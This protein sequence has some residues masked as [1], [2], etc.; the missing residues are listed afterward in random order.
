MPE[1]YIDPID[2][3][4]PNHAIAPGSPRSQSQP[5]ARAPMIAGEVIRVERRSGRREAGHVLDATVGGHA[6]DE[7]VIR[8]DTG[9]VEGLMGQRVVV[10]LRP[11]GMGP[12]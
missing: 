9:S 7:I 10:N 11:E 3:V 2:N 1:D 4:P 8:V 5:P 6:R 12:V